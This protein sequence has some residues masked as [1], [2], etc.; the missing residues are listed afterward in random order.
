M[1]II[2]LVLH[3]LVHTPQCALSYNL[4]YI[5]TGQNTA[6][7]EREV[8]GA[9]ALAGTKHTHMIYSTFYTPNPNPH[10]T[11]PLP[12]SLSRSASL[13]GLKIAGPVG[14]LAFGALSNYLGEYTLAIYF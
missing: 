7:K 12:L 4:S 14:A 3:P 2:S 5:F 11:E 10:L 6:E 9:A 1:L 8:V 13:L